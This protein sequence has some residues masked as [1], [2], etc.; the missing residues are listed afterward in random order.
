MRRR[1]D[2]TFSKRLA[3]MHIEALNPIDINQIG[4][5][6]RIQMIVSRLFSGRTKNK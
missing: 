2:F 4:Q 1:S 5:F 6:G 3:K